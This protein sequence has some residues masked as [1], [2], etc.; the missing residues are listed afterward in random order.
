MSGGALDDGVQ[1]LGQA[2]IAIEA[3]RR[4]FEGL[5]KPDEAGRK[6]RIAITGW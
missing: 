6:L 2:L 5:V 1:P 3:R 4:C